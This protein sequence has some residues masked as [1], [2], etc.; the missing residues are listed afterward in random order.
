MIMYDLKLLRDV[1]CFKKGE[2]VRGNCSST[3]DFSKFKRWFLERHDSENLYYADNGDPGA[4]R[5]LFKETFELI[6]I[7]S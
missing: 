3:S 4:V 7:I 1:G 6:T 5:R 2:F